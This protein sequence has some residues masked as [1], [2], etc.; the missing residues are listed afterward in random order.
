MA[1]LTGCVTVAVFYI[2]G[3][4]SVATP[5]PFLLLFPGLLAG[6]VTPGSG[7]NLKD[8]T[9]PLS[10]VSLVVACAVNVA[11]YGGVSFLLFSMTN[12]RRRAAK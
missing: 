5:L 2:L 12:R 1:L 9:H 4:L 8:D 10:A 7:F 3:R 11:I 6:A